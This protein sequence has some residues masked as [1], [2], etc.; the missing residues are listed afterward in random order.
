MEILIKVSDTGIGIPAEAVP[1]V[2]DRFFRVDPSRCK[3]SGGTG[4]G[5]AI[6]Q[7]IMILFTAAEQR[8]AASSAGEPVSLSAC[9]WRQTFETAAM[10][11]KVIRFWRRSRLVFAPMIR[12]P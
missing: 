11:C 5:L 6:V 2:F 3:T 9:L 4:L 12:C 1:R 7:S 8:S 10:P